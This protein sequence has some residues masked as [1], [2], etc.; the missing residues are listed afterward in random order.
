MEYSVPIDN[1][2]LLLLLLGKDEGF[3]WEGGCHQFLERDPEFCLQKG[4]ALALSRVAGITGNNMRQYYTLLKA[5]L[6]K[7]GILNCPR[8]IY[9]MD[10][11]G[12]AL[13][14]KSPKVIARKWTKKIHRCTSGNKA[15]N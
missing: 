9:N 12:K 3:N 2:L 11:S 1:L 6:E 5:T 4:D 7:Y 14:H 13:D 8:Q 10:E 15:Q